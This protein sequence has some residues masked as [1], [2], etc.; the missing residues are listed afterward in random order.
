[1]SFNDKTILSLPSWLQTSFPSR[2]NTDLAVACNS[3][4]LFCSNGLNLQ[5][6][7]P[8][9]F[10]LLL[11]G[12]LQIFFSGPVVCFSTAGQQRNIHLSIPR[13]TNSRQREIKPADVDQNYMISKLHVSTSFLFPPNRTASSEARLEATFSFFSC[14]CFVVDQTQESR[15]PELAILPTF[16]RRL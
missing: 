12:F 4:E 10:C 9:F 15:F 14:F 6:S 1:M 13:Q 11:V 2:S 3:R 7:S 5:M 16:Q 8:G